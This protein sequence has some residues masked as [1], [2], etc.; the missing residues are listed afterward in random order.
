MFEN[1]F[2]ISGA[3]YEQILQKNTKKKKMSRL[4]RRVRQ[5]IL[6]RHVGFSPEAPC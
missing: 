6:L 1:N 2:Q 5:I 4:A 3:A